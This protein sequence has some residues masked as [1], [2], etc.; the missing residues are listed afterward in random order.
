MIGNAAA[1]LKLRGHHFNAGHAD[2]VLAIAGKPMTLLQLAFAR[3]ADPNLF[4]RMS[5][6]VEN[7]RVFE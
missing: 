6:L 3:T 5:G 2:D 4:L 1:A 7:G